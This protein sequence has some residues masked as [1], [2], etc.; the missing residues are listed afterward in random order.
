MVVLGG[1]PAGCAASLLLARWGHRVVLLT[2]PAPGPPLAESLTPS[3][4]RLLDR[5]GVL[6]AMD[7]ARFVRS[8]GHTVRW[9]ATPAR[10]EPFAGTAR[11]WQVRRDHLDTLLQRHAKTA[12]AQLHRHASIRRVSPGPGGVRVTYEERGQARDVLAQWAID[13]T[14]RAGLMSRAGSGREPRGRRT[15]ALVATWERRGGWDI[16][17]HTHTLVESVAGG[18]A[19][20][21]PLSRVRRQVTV[22]LDPERSAVASA[23]RLQLTYRSALAATT[24]MRMACDRAR[25]VGSPWAR[26]ASSYACPQVVKNRVLIAGDAASFV[27]PLSSFG[28]KKALASGWLAAVVANTVVADPGLRVPALDL[29]MARE[30]A[31]VG[32]LDRQL[33][34]LAAEAAAGLPADR[35][36]SFWAD[37]TDALAA[38]AGGEPDAVALRNDPD[39]RAAFDRIRATDVLRIRPHADVERVGRPYVQGDRVTVGDHFVSDAFPEGIRFIR[40]VDLVRLADLATRHAGVPDIH[41]AYEAGG[42]AVALPDFLGALAVL[43][44]KRLVEVA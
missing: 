41:A 15:L 21:V 1:G 3:A 23:G 30:R 18:W 26:D 33:R 12:G 17:D 9:G 28:V 4:A 19:W 11:G 22:M 6:P 7:G 40:N 14:G 39:V 10:V 25:L 2:R 16:E 5:L 20:S 38:P 32:A 13:C 24:M 37:R 27:D 36:G 42:A 35:E 44:G 29:F 43:V 31:M 8:T 34:A